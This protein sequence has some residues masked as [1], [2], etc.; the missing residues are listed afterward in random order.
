LNEKV[1]NMIE[2][3]YEN[4]TFQEIILAIEI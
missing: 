1:K 4:T 2:I 3:N